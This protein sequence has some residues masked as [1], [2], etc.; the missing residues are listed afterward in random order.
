MIDIINY[1]LFKAVY[2]NTVIKYYNTILKPHLTVWA[3]YCE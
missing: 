2:G 1:V 3:H